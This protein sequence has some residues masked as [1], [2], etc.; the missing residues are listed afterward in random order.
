[1][2]LFDMK[3]YANTVKFGKCGTTLCDMISFPS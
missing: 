2:K 1:M 3:N